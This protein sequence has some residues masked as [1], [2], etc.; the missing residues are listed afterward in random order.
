MHPESSTERSA[1]RLRAFRHM[2]PELAS[3]LD[4]ALA[5]QGAPDE[6]APTL[7][8]ELDQRAEELRNRMLGEVGLASIANFTVRERLENALVAARRI[9]TRISVTPPE[10]EVFEGAGTDLAAL[11]SALERDPS[12]VPVIAPYGLQPDEWREAF[13][14]SGSEHLT[15]LVLATDVEREFAL[16]NLPPAG[17][18]AHPSD[19]RTLHWTFR[20]I[21]AA[22]APPK[23]GLSYAHG[24]H[25]TL[26]E[27]LMVQLLQAEAGNPPIDSRTFTWL[28]G[29][30]GGGKLA[31]R[32]VYDATELAV[33]VSSREI[34]HQGPHLG[35][36]PPVPP[37]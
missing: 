4:A 10:F 22:D 30:L 9:L 31:T 35:A 15:T 33:R 21:P 23:L 19:G 25:T 28:A 13:A 37:S 24:P 18:V 32:H 1:E 7:D 11:A 5:R 8:A 6:S 3:R 20:L 26:P 17:S 16:V 36:R 29:T 2:F 14:T 12:L 27:M 34:G